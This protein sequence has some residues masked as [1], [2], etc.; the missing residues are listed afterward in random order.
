MHMLMSFIG[1]VGNL[2]TE[3]GLAD[4]MSLAFAGV[5]KMLVG[6]KFPMCMRALRMVVEVIHEA[7]LKELEVG[8]CDTLIGNLKEKAQKSRTC[9]LAGFSDQTCLLDD[10]LCQS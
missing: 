2:M 3:T 7:V 5:H 8:C 1:A 9:T 4:I 10:V 6:K